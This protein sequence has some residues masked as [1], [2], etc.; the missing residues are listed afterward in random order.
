MLPNITI[1]K[2]LTA[3]GNI[4]LLVNGAKELPVRLLAG[5]EIT[6]IRQRLT[7]KSK[8]VIVINRLGSLVFVCRIGKGKTTS[9][10]LEK[11]RKKGESLLGT[12]QEHKLAH[13]T[14]LDEGDY[15]LE[16]LSIAEGLMLGNYQFLK[17]RKD[18]A[19]KESPLQTIEIISRSLKKEKAEQ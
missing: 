9:K 14:L 2:K 19:E 15:H 5:P 18:A 4:I 6:Y 12:I 8:D 7:D 10:R 1:S 17:Y 16:T 3:T 13:I 11:W